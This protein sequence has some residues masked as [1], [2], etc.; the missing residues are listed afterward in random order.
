MG[1]DRFPTPEKGVVK[2][3]IVTA[4]YV[5]SLTIDQNPPQFFSR[6]CGVAD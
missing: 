2:R 6:R 1:A 4:L 5:G 3:M